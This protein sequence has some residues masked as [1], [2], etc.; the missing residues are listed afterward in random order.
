MALFIDWFKFRITIMKYLTYI[1][2]V[3]FSHFSL[4]ELELVSCSNIEGV[5]VDFISGKASYSPDGYNGVAISLTMDTISGIEKVHYTGSIQRTG[6]DAEIVKSERGNDDFISW[7]KYFN[8]V[9]K[10]YTIYKKQGVLSLV[11]IQ[12]KPNTGSPQIRTYF[13]SCNKGVY[14]G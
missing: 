2:L 8:D 5:S 14:G 4:S 12:T 13:G 11:E 6:E 10:I 1:I 9:H 3:T 7:S